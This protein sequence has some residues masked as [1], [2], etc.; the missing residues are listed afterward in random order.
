[1]AAI[2][3]LRRAD[4]DMMSISQFLNTIE[5]IVEDAP[6]DIEVSAT[7]GVNSDT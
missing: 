4:S 2:S 7:G 6:T 3:E 1:M 5:E